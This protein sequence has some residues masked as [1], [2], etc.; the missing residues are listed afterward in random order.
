MEIK[1][2]MAATAAILNEQWRW[3]LKGTFTHSPPINHKQIGPVDPGVCQI[4][5]RNQIQDGYHEK[6][7]QV[8]REGGSPLG[9]K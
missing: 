8:E 7:D 4:I 1:S 6:R 2:K 5:V 3:S 9:R